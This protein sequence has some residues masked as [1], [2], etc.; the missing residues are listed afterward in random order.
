MI[1]KFY[2]HI[3]KDSLYVNSLFLMA[4]TFVTAGLGF[5]FWIVIA[6]FF[7]TESVGISTTLISVMTFISGLSCLGFDT[8]IVRYLSKSKNKNALISSTFIITGITTLLVS[9][10]FLVGI[11]LFSP[12]LLFLRDNFIIILSFLLFMLFATWNIILENIFVSYRATVNIFIMNSVLSVLKLLFPLVL[13]VFGP[14]GIFS[15]VALATLFSVILGGLILHK[16]FTFRPSITIDSSTVGKM[17]RFSGGSYISLLILQIPSFLIPII[18]LNFLKADFVAYYY[19]DTMLLNFLLIIP[20]ATTQMLLSEGSYN[21]VML[22]N[23]IK[24]TFYI[25]SAFLVPG[26]FSILLFGNFV[27]Y[28]F[29]KNYASEAFS[30]LQIISISSIFISLTLL[31]GAILRVKHKIKELIFA[32]LIGTIIT[33]TLCY[34]LI[35]YKLVGI[36]WGILIGD[37]VASG[38]YLLF[39]FEELKGLFDGNRLLFDNFVNKYTK[40][41]VPS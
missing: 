12:K 32:N 10:I 37:I 26:I 35:P 38:L 28:I 6:R 33:L 31:C 24:K 7:T 13:V 34:F 4:S 23:H 27:L 11:H 19:I 14:Y 20:F 3:I 9:L 36:G 40:R 2:T 8:G 41:I 30:F 17:A 16:K 15:S 21:E 25:I 5:I 22:K 18:I 1:K 39:T 29:G